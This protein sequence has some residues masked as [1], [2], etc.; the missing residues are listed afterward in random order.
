MCYRRQ[1]CA[2]PLVSQSI[3]HRSLC[4]WIASFV[5]IAKPLWMG[6]CVCVYVFVLCRLT[7]VQCCPV[8]RA[9]RISLRLFPA[10]CGHCPLNWLHLLCQLDSF[11]YFY[12][13]TVNWIFILFACLGEELLNFNENLTFKLIYAFL[14]HRFC[15][16]LG[17]LFH[18]VQDKI[19]ICS[20]CIWLIE[21]Y[22]CK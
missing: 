13:F 10:F 2:T 1:E 20:F 4:N 19:N 14:L 12:F 7:I 18:E 22:W 15:S 16:T 8:Q 17:I 6:M 9:Q 3:D 11:F 5:L 21:R